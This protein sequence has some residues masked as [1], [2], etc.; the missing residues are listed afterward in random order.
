MDKREWVEKAPITAETVNLVT[1]DSQSIGMTTDTIT[2]LAEN[3]D[4]RIGE[5]RHAT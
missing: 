4:K 5:S 3:L 1:V 2:E